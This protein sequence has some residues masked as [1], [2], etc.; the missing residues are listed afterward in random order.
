MSPVLKPLSSQGLSS[1]E[2]GRR[3]W[4]RVVVG[5]EGGRQGWEG[6]LQLGPGVWAA[7]D[8]GPPRLSVSQGGSQQGCHL[9]G[10]QG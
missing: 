4:A 2:K 6:T 5:G 9:L 8:W 3:E 7:C 10:A 1:R